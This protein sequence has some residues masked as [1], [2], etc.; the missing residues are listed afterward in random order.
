MKKIIALIFSFLCVGMI[1][2][3]CTKETETYFYD[4]YDNWNTKTNATDSNE[5]YNETK[6]IT[7]NSA[8][9][10]ALISSEFSEIKT[11]EKIFTGLKN[12]VKQLSFDFVHDPKLEGKALKNAQAT[13]S[14]YKEQLRSYEAEIEDFQNAKNNFEVACSGLDESGAGIIEKDEYKA[15]LSSYRTLIQSLTEVYSKMYACAKSMFYSGEIAGFKSSDARMSA[16]KEYVYQAK[17]LIIKDYLYFCYE[18]SDSQPQE[19]KNVIMENYNKIKNLAIDNSKVE[20]AEEKLPNI[21][22]KIDALNTW[23]SYYKTESARIKEAMDGG[24]FKYSLSGIETNNAQNAAIKENH[25]K[26]LTLINS[27]MKNLSKTCADLVAFY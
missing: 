7:F 9:I 3:G 8:N 18:H 6:N 19:Y 13:V 21:D 22:A 24:K 26:Y 11:Y 1:F 5:F 10:N 17:I 27:T 14:E 23:L 20:Q 2:V 4:V 15:F 16:V 12:D 25:E